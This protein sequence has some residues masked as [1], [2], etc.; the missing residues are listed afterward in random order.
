MVGLLGG[1]IGVYFIYIIIA[2]I[3]KHKFA[4]WFL[5][6]TGILML[7]TS[8][9]V[10]GELLS[11][12]ISCICLAILIHFV[13]FFRVRDNKKVKIAPETTQENET[14]FANTTKTE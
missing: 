14:N 7:I 11:T 6:T 9:F 4:F 13:K 8:F 5:I 12:A 10:G 1:M 3:F 2:L